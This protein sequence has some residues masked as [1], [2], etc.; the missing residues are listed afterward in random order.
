MKTS[1]CFPFAA[2]F[3]LACGQQDAPDAQA[4]SDPAFDD[5]QAQV[6]QITG[7]NYGTPAGPAAYSGDAE[8]YNTQDPQEPASIG[9]QQPMQDQ[10]SMRTLTVPSSYPG[11]AL[12]QLQVPA[13]WNVKTNPSGSWQVDEADLKVFDVKG[14]SFMYGNGQMAQ[15]YQQAGGSLRQPTPPAQLVVQD[16]V[17]RMRQIGFELTG[18]QDLP[19]VAQAEQRGLDGLYS[20]DQVRKTCLSNLSE[21]RKGDERVALMMHWSS[22]QSPDMVKWSYYLTRLNAPAARFDTEKQALVA[23]YSSLRYNP[24]YFAAYAGGEQQQA[25]RSWAAHNQR[26][27]ANQATFDAQQQTHRETW[28]AINDASMGAYRDRMNSMD[29]MQNA[30]IN[31]IRGEQ[32]AINPYTGEQGKIQ[33]GYDQYW[34]NSDGQYF[35]TNDPNYDPNVNSDWV[36]QWRQ[37]PAGK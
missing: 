8:G 12:A 25:Q 34:M 16:L 37:A 14:G 27:Q 22:F 11:I 13:R 26:M 15:F 32:D 35:G 23:A 1:V 9:Q 29:R 17:P 33:S 20:V 10:G 3:L 30:T 2:L 19:A 7:K 36:D 5:L 4:T 6:A 24:A 21:W 18:Q 28:G 31:G